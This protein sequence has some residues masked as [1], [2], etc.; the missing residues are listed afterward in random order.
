MPSFPTSV[1]APATRSNGQTIDA[2]HINSL[3]DE[4]V[5]IEGGYLNG[6]ARLNSSA[7]TLVALSVSGGSTLATLQVNG[8]STFAGG[9]AFTS[10]VTFGS[11]VTISSGGM[12]ISSGGLHISTGALTLGQGQVVFPGTQVASADVNTLDDYEEGSWTP[13]IGGAGGTSGQAYGKQIGRYVKVGKQ[14]TVWCVVVL[15]TEGTIT[16]NVEIQGLPFAAETIA[17]WEQVAG[18]FLF[19]GLATN[20]IGVTGFV[21]SNTSVV[22]VRGTAAAGANNRTALTATDIG[23]TSGFEFTLTYRA[24]N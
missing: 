3:Q 17:N 18:P 4:V 6:T 24:A 16:G 20:W 23:D 8:G 11:S 7:S 21:A 15:S 19:E 2:S 13:V 22:A 10:T 5:A 14:V 1:F 12:N 9:I